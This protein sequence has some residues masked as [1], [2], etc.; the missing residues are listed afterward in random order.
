M[1]ATTATQLGENVFANVQCNNCGT[2]IG[3]LIGTD[4]CPN[5][6]A[7]NQLI[8]LVGVIKNATK[9]AQQP[10]PVG[11]RLCRSTQARFAR[12]CNNSCGISPVRRCRLSQSVS[13]AHT[14]LGK[15]H[16][17]LIY[18]RKSRQR[19]YFY[20]GKIEINIIKYKHKR[21]LRWMI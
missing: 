6:G 11:Q 19:N 18:K 16:N 8:P 21:S 15:K 7:K 9:A 3:L 10:A 20:C 1:N 2:V 4:E 12:I 13:P 5:C 17:D 14:I